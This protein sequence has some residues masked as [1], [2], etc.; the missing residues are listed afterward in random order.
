MAVILNSQ[1]TTRHQAQTV[2]QILQA[3][4]VGHWRLLFGIDGVANNKFPVLVD[5]D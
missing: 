5:A 2:G 3:D 4:S 1:L